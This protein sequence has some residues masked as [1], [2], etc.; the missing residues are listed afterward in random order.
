MGRT[1][2]YFFYRYQQGRP[3]LNIHDQER[4]LVREAFASDA[5]ILAQ[6]R[7]PEAYPEVSYLAAS[8]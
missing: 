2:P 5:S 7:D 1:E 3:I 8:L 6:W 4:R